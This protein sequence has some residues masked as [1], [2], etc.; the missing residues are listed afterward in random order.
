MHLTEGK[1]L[2][3]DTSLL[4]LDTNGNT[5]YER[6]ELNIFCQCLVKYSSEIY[7]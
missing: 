1:L 3:L 2:M 5:I 7:E 6:T 4:I